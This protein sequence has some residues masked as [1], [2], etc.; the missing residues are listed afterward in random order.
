MNRRKSIKNSNNL[1]KDHLELKTIA[2]YK[3]IKEGDIF[4]YEMIDND[5]VSRTSLKF[6]ALND[7]PI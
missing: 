3:A 7:S 2:Q 5:E 1:N 4:T 6:L